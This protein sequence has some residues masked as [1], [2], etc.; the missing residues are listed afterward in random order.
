VR[1]LHRVGSDR[2]SVQERLYRTAFDLL[3]QEIAAVEELSANEAS[4][5]IVAALGKQPITPAKVRN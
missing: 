4:D 1:D 3:S 5:K 2:G